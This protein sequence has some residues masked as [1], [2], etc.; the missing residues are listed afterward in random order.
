MLV[1]MMGVSIVA[2]TM[3]FSAG[4]LVASGVP[5]GWFLLALG[6]GW[7]GMVQAALTRA[8]GPTQDTDRS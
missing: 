2:I 6:T 3:V 7:L 4:A 8:A 5:L 1:L